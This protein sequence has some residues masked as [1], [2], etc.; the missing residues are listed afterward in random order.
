MKDAAFGIFLP[1]FLHDQAL[2]Q[3]TIDGAIRTGNIDVIKLVAVLA[4]SRTP[5]TEM[6]R[7]NLLIEMVR[8]NEVPIRKLC[9][10]SLNH[11]VLIFRRVWFAIE[12]QTDEQGRLLSHDV[13][14]VYAERMLVLWNYD[15]QVNRTVKT[16]VLERMN[17]IE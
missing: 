4:K 16:S 14:N 3:K 7:L 5:E 9:E 8:N 6:F 12:Q 13:L 15:R 10:L 17:T 11:N 2:L 1:T